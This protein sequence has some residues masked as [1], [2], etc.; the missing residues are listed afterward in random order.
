MERIYTWNWTTGG[1]NSCTA[2]SLAEAKLKAA[3]IGTS[4]FYGCRVTLVADPKTF[5]A[6]TQAEMNAIDSSWASAFD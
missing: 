2:G 3:A 1:Y 5:R 4:S 6:V